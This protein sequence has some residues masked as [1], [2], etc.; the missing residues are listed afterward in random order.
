V[1]RPRSKDPRLLRKLRIPVDDAVVGHF[2][3]LQPVKR[4]LDVVESAAFVLRSHPACC[5]LVAGAGPCRPEMERLAHQRGIGGQFRFVGRIEHALVPRYMSLCD[6]V[7]LPS[8][9]ESFSL[10]YREAQ[11]CGRVIVASDIPAAR[12]AIEP[13]RTGALFRRGDPRDLATVTLRLLR[14][15]ARRRRIA[16]NARASVAK[17]TLLNWTREYAEVLQQVVYE[18]A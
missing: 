9:R 18:G 11:A 13:G 3:S 15:R 17:Q 8:E 6:L 4:P 16:A 1:F 5:Y 2:S 14:N 10:V 7:V 12:E